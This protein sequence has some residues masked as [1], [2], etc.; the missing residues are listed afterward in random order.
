MKLNA[1]ISVL[2][3]N[4]LR[5]KYW[6]TVLARLMRGSANKTCPICGFEGRFRAFGI[7]P[8]MDAECPKCES[9]ERHRLFALMLQREP[10]IDATTKLLHFAPEQAL[11]TLLAKQAGIYHTADLMSSSVDLRLDITGMP[12]I[13]T[14][15]YDAVL[16]SHV[17]EHVDDRAALAEIFRILKPGGVLMAM[18]PL[19]AGWETSYENAAITGPAERIAHFGQYDHVR[20]Y[21]RDFRTRITDAGFCLTTFTA[22]GED[23]VRYGL[24]R[25]ETV[26]LAHKPAPA[27]APGVRQQRTD[28][29][30]EQV[31]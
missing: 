16:C 25:G 17:L 4:A 8:R 28:D 5:A 12:D 24:L 13:G 1:A 2:N 30:E 10:Q 22:G 23:S 9:L 11:S 31:R 3:K 7:P 26:F 27:A 20:Y 18:V 19:I 6:V 14:A 15:S 21:G 29:A